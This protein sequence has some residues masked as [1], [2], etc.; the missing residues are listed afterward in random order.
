MFTNL[1]AQV[2]TLSKKLQDVQ[3]KGPQLSAHMVEESPP[4]CDHCEGAHPT[5]QCSMMNSMEELT[6]EQAQYLLNFPHNHN[7]NQ[8]AQSYNPGWKNHPNFSWKNYN[9]VNPMEQ[10]KPSPPPQEKKSSLDLKLE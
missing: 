10:V 4:E 6:I 7:F 5:S 2:S 1:A 3:K 9:V 8:Y